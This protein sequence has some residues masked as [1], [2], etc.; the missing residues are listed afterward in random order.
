MKRL[1][2]SISLVFPLSIAVLVLFAPQVRAITV[3]G[4]LDAGYGSALAVQTIGTGFGNAAGGDDAAG[5]SELDA[6]YGV[7]SGGNLYLFLAG[8]FENNGNHLNIF[9]GSSDVPGQNVLNIGSSTEAAMNGSTFSPGFSPNYMIDAND[10]AGTVYVDGFSLPNGGTAA[11]AY[12]GSFASGS[13]GTLGSLTLALIN[14]NG[15][16]VDGSAG[17]SEPGVGATVTT[18]MELAIPLS[19]IGS[20]SGAIMVMAD[21]NGGGD[22]YLSNQF[23]PGLPGGTGNVGGGGPYTGGSSSQFNFGST[24]GEYFTVAVPE[25]STIGLMLVGLLGALA[26]RRRKA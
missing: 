7:I 24:P 13:S 2:Y 12:L 6:A 8:N 19:T 9:I 3:D 22:G 21:V 17:T 10:Y 15:G 14:S 26:I 1:V 16:G 23:L 5:G 20:P 25:P 4:N 18:G 11:Q